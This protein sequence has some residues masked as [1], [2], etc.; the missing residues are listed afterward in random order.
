MDATLQK[1]FS[2][3]RQGVRV[4]LEAFNLWNIAQRTAPNVQVLHALFGSYTAVTQP[5]A[6]QFTL[7][8]DF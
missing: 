7:Q 3:G 4:T 1:R 6:L 5:R 8:Y 2:M